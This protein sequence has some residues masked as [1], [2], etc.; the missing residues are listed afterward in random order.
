MKTFYFT[1]TG[2]SLYVAKR[3]GGEFCS[4]PQMLKQGQTSFADDAIGF[5]FPCH[6]FGL[7]RLVADFIARSHFEA[8]YFFGVMTYGGSAAAALQ[9]LETVGRS[10]GITFKYTNDILMVDNFFPIFGAEKALERDNTKIFEINLKQIVRD[11]QNRENKLKRKGKL[12]T[13]ASQVT[14]RLVSTTLYAVGDRAFTVCDTCNGCGIC[15]QVCPKGNIRFYGHPEFLHQCD[16]CLACIHHCPQKAIQ[17]K[18]KKS[19]ARFINPHVSLQE[20]IAANNQEN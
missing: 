14:N 6:A 13:A 19:S 15:A 12:T 5:V 10:A 17:L 7:P 4:I 11:I 8:D 1:A 18:F 3:I 20:I 2:N 16:C 9:Q